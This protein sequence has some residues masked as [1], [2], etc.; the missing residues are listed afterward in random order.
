MKCII[1][2]LFSI[3]FISVYRTAISLMMKTTTSLTQLRR[4]Q[5]RK[6]VRSKRGNGK[7]ELKPVFENENGKC[8]EHSPHIC[9]TETRRGSI[10]DTQRRS[11]ISTLFSQTWY[12][13]YFAIKYQT[14]TL[15]LILSYLL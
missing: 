3:F 14:H 9:V 10:I 12:C 7:E 6:I 11:N 1:R 13:G 8:K 5:L 2:S 4:L 15:Y